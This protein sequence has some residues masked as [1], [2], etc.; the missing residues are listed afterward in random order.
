MDVAYLKSRYDKGEAAYINCPMNKEEYDAFYDALTKSEKVVPKDFENNV[1]EGCMPVEVMASRGRETLLFGPLKPV[2]LEQE[3]K[4]RPYAVVQLRQDDAK[5]TMY[6]IVGFQTHMTWG[7][8]KRVIQMIPG[9]E[10][11]NI[12]RYGVMHRNTYIESPQVLN[13]G[14]Q[15][16]DYPKLFVAGQ[17]SG[18]EGYVESAA[19]GLNAAIQL[20]SYLN[21]RKIVPFPEDTMIG[22]MAHY[23]SS[24]NVSFVPMN[25]NFG[26]LPELGHKHPKKMRKS[27]YAE[28]ALKSL[29]VFKELNPWI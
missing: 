10:N 20:T 24:P 21:D 17:I 29:S 9:L 12:L 11:A 28:R 8:Q 15:S 7:E 6:N 3:G 14:F 4:D 13:Q 2:G 19:S 18:V 1:F 22:S 25:A 5:Q 23:I 26:L 16:K 27:L